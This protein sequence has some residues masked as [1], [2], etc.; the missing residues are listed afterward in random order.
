MENT[1]A[2]V[3]TEKM[4]DE[5]R[6]MRALFGDDWEEARKEV[7]RRCEERLKFNVPEV[8]S[9]IRFPYQVAKVPNKDLMD[10]MIAGLMANAEDEFKTIFTNAVNDMH[11]IMYNTE[12]NPTAVHVVLIPSGKMAYDVVWQHEDEDSDVAV[13]FDCVGTYYNEKD[14]QAA[15]DFADVHE[16]MEE[17][18]YIV[19]YD[20]DEMWDV[21]YN[22][23]RGRVFLPYFPTRI[24]ALAF[25]L[26]ATKPESYLAFSEHMKKLREKYEV[27][28]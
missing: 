28:G 5:E 17:E 16:G 22:D 7:R 1:K 21:L 19:K 4:G 3:V 12:D 11:A 8:E 23:G 26:N 10:S 20:P 9:L 13:A 27:A 2:A 24:R 25:A 18:Y 15:L 14:A 6:L